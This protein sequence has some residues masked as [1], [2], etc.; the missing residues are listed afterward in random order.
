MLACVGDEARRL[1]C[2]A[3]LSICIQHRPQLCT[4]PTPLQ[5][6]AAHRQLQEQ[7]LAEPAA[8]A[9]LHSEADACCAAQLRALR[10]LYFTPIGESPAAQSSQSQPMQPHAK[11][12]QSQAQQP[13]KAHQQHAGTGG[14]HE[15]VGL[16]L[17]ELQHEELMCRLEIFTQRQQQAAAHT[18]QGEAQQAQH[19]QREL[20]WLEGCLLLVLVQ[21]RQAERAATETAEPGVAKQVR[22]SRQGFLL[23][24][25]EVWHIFCFLFSSDSFV[26]F[27]SMNVHTSS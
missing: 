13:S 3:H 14:M 17:C 26:C 20:L 24:L 27:S 16:G 25:L 2:A 8:K 19:T 10:G 22:P 18:P 11:Q 6:V 4:W 1:H 23:A 12:S 5:V 15:V 7:R 9:H 21:L